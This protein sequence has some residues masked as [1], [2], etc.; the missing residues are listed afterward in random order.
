MTC[1]QFYHMLLLDYQ[2][3]FF[4]QVQ[5]FRFSPMSQFLVTLTGTY[6]R[7]PGKTFF[8]YATFFCFLSH[9]H[10]HLLLFHFCF[11]FNFLPSNSHLHL[12]E[13]CF[14]DVYD[15]FIPFIILIDYFQIYIF[16]FLGYTYSTKWIRNSITTSIIPA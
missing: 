1:L 6:S 16:Y 2:R 15:S 5:S 14:I 13:V 4:M 9:S 8:A 10:W 12:Y 7:I 11:E 3:V